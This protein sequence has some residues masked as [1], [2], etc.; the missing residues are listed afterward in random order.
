MNVMER[1]KDTSAAFW[2]MIIPQMYGSAFHMPMYFMILDRVRNLP[3]FM[4]IKK[5]NQ[6]C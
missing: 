5:M 1:K 3:N 6:I 2:P 4:L